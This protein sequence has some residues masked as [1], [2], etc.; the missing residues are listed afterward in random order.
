VRPPP[1]PAA[2]PRLAAPRTS[3]KPITLAAAG[4]PRTAAC[5]RRAAYGRVRPAGRVRPSL[6]RLRSGDPMRND[7]A[8]SDPNP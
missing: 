4:G 8:R 3:R 7:A 2:G 6:P 1:G 5:G